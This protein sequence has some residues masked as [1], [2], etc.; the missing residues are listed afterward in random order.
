MEGNKDNFIDSE[1]NLINDQI[2]K[3]KLM[4]KIMI[5]NFRYLFHNK[6][7]LLLL[8]LMPLLAL[9][10]PVF[11][12]PLFYSFPAY[13][14]LGVIGPAG[15]TYCSTTYEWR[16]GTLYNVLL[17]TKSSKYIFYLASF[18]VMLMMVWI[19]YF[20]T[21]G[22]LVSMNQVGMLSDGWGFLE[23]HISYLEFGRIYFLPS[24]YSLFEMTLIAFA[25][26][27]FFQNLVKTS[28]S[29]YIVIFAI[30]VL[31]VVFGGLFTQYFQTTIDS[32]DS[33]TSVPQF[34]A[35]LF[36]EDVFWLAYF[37]DPLFGPSMHIQSY[38]S[39]WLYNYGSPAYGGDNRFIFWIWET[40][41]NTLGLADWSSM[42]KWNILW[43]TPYIWTS[44]FGGFGILVSKIKN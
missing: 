33:G 20:I 9:I 42:F 35:Q 2:S 25:I 34:K 10:I 12:A 44:L 36:P 19:L 31:Q 40:K 39:K 3:F 38:S 28:V 17:T 30:A 7:N 21:L 8:T 41:S 4:I 26:C 24:V 16:R 6:K 43:L 13:V 5:L 27:F 11:L 23:N 22:L 14:T 1:H 37:M 32:V 29:L 18:L 15:I